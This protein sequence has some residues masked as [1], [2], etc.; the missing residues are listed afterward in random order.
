MSKGNRYFAVKIKLYMP[1]VSNPRAW[2]STY[3]ED[4]LFDEEEYR[5]SHAYIEESAKEA[6]GLFDRIEILNIEELTKADFEHITKDGDWTDKNWKEQ[7]W[8]RKEQF[9][10]EQ[11][12]KNSQNTPR[13]TPVLTV[14]EGGK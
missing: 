3:I 9:W 8:E 4:L 2:S 6:F 1:W 10:K 14:L 12:I 7:L 13:R 11:A 5:P